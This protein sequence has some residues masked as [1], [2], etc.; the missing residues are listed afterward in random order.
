MKTIILFFLLSLSVCSTFASNPPE[1]ILKILDTGDEKPAKKAYKVYSIQEEYDVL[2][3]LKIK[4]E[5]QMLI[6]I[7]GQFYDVFKAGNKEIYFQIVDKT[8]NRIL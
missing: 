4:P 6:I 5:Q 3:Y 7:D 1:R 2:E 8:Q